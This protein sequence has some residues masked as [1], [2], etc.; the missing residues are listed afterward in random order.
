MCLWGHRLPLTCLSSTWGFQ[1]LTGG[2]KFWLLKQYNTTKCINNLF[3]TEKSRKSKCNLISWS[4]SAGF[5][6]KY[7]TCDFHLSSNS[8]S[9][10]TYHISNTLDKLDSF[11][12]SFSSLVSTGKTAVRAS[13]CLAPTPPPHLCHMAHGRNPKGNKVIYLIRAKTLF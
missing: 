12:I 13:C 4:C 10:T 2:F 6:N 3:F 11:I 8:V 1:K 5:D 9:G 7:A